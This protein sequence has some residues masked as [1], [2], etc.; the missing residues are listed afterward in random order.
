MYKKTLVE[1]HLSNLIMV[2]IIFRK[3]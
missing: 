2:S 3:H 1:T